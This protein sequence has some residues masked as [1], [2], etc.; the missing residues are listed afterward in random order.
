MYPASDK[1]RISFEG[2][3]A[4]SGDLVTIRI[5]GINGKVHFFQQR[6]GANGVVE[7]ELDGLPTGLYVMD[8][9]QFPGCAPKRL[10]LYPY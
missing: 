10:V 2:E 7:L 1:V 9:P 3:A 4:F 6:R 8:A 5:T